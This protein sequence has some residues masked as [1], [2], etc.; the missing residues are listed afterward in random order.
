MVWRMSSCTSVESSA[1]SSAQ[2]GIDTVSWITP[3]ER[4]RAQRLTKQWASTWLSDIVDWIRVAGGE[5]PDIA[6]KLSQAGLAPADA[7]LR[8]GFGRIDSTRDT[9]I[10]RVTKGT[11]GIKDAV[12]QVQDFRRLAA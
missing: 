8:L 4:D 9:I 3:E 10:T 6:V 2:I 12:R 7:E 1:D 5:H 11:L